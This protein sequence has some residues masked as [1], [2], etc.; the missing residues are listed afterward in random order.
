MT[1]APTE[2]PVQPTTAPVATATIPQTGDTFPMTLLL[3]VVFGSIAAIGVLT[4]KRHKSET[5]SEEDN[6]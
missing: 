2:A 1:A 3:V 5:D 4:Y 6:Q